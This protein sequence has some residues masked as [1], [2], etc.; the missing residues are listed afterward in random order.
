MRIF[1]MYKF[2]PY[3]LRKDN[4]NI[5]LVSSLQSEL[6]TIVGNLDDKKE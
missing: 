1:N 6:P 5:F 2:V 3:W 4:L